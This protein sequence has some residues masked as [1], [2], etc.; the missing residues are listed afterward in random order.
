MNVAQ[1]NAIPCLFSAYRSV[2]RYIAD[3]YARGA[4]L[5][6][7]ELLATVTENLNASGTAENGV[8]ASST[9]D[10]Q[11]YNA[12][13]RDLHLPT[14]IRDQISQHTRNDIKLSRGDDYPTSEDA[15]EVF[16]K[17]LYDAYVAALRAQEFRCAVSGIPLSIK[18]TFA[19][20][21][22]DRTRGDSSQPHFTADGKLHPDTRFIC[23]LFNSVR[24]VSRKQLV[25]FFL[26]QELV[27]ITDAV[28]AMAE[29]KFASLS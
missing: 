14:I 25:H 16:R 12:E 20:F 2:Y 5:D 23:R 9:T 22:L 24:G 1:H 28:R 26:S 19:R 27:P 4:P 11:L 17:S 10:P 21:S 13:M 8:T 6:T 29:A 3:I 15:R 7:T 18:N